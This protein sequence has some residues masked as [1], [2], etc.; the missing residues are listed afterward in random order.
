VADALLPLQTGGSGFLELAVVFVLLAIV[1]AIAGAR[2]VAGISATI[3]KWLVI[4]FLVL[5]VASFLL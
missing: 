3:A 5:A 1:A 4:I 2:G